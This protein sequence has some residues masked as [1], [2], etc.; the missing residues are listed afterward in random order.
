MK[1]WWI[2]VLIVGVLVDTRLATAQTPLAQPG[3]RAVDAT[4]GN[5]VLQ[6]RYLGA[7]PPLT[8]VG[9]NLDFGALL[10]E[11]R[12]FVASAAWMFDTDVVPVSRLRLQVGPRADLAWLATGSKTDVFALGIGAGVR[13][14]LIRRLGLSAFGSG[15]YS[16]GVLTFGSAHNLYDFTAGAEIKLAGRLY[17]LGGYRWF[18]FT[19]VNEPDERLVNEVFAGVRWQL[20]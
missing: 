9:G 10:T 14:E 6:L 18:K 8:G 2:L 20:E 3:E 17:A 7:A 1:S 11:S 19:L 15:G 13:Y 16:P 5:D 12:E 4:V